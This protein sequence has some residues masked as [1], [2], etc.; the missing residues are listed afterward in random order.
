MFKSINVE[1]EN[2]ELILENSHGDKVII[3]A[4]KRNW[5]K[6]KLSEGCHDCIDSLV[7]TLPVASQY[8]QDGSVYPPNAKVKV[9]HNN[10]IKEYDISSPEYRDLYNSGK[11]MSYD[12]TTDTY[13]AT[14]LKEVTVT[15]EA[16]QWLKYKRDYEKTNP[17]S[18]YINNHLTPFAKS[19]GNTKT[20]Y[21]KR[22]DDEYEQKSL[23]YVSEQLIK[24]KPQGKL[25]RVEWLNQMSDKEEEL[26]KRNPKYQSSLWADT[27]RGLT[28]LVEQNPLQ[29]F[30]NILN[31]SDYTNREKQEMLKDYNNHPVMSKLGDATKILNPL[32][33]PSK[34]VQSSYKDDYSFSDAL[35]GKKN[36]AGIVED[37]VTDPLNLVGLGIWGKLSKANKFKNLD[38]AYNAIK[39]LDKVSLEKQLGNT[40]SNEDWQYLYR[41][42]EKGFDIEK[43][44]LKA[45][46]DRVSAGEGKWYDHNILNNP[47]LRSNIQSRDKYYGQWFDSDPKRLDYYLADKGEEVDILRTKVPKKILDQYRIDKIDPEIAKKWSLSHE[48]EYIVP[49]DLIQQAEKFDKK[50][51]Q[52]LIDEYELVN[53]AKPIVSSVDDVGKQAS[54]QWQLEELP[55]LHLK[56]T[57]GNNP[58][59]LHTQVAKDGS[60]NTENALKFIKNNEGEEKYN[61]IRQAFGK[62]LPNKMNYNEFRKVVQDQLIPLEKQFSEH[63]S[64]YGIGK[65]GYPS[66]KRSS[67]EAAIT[68]ANVE[69]EKQLQIIKEYEGYL[70]NPNKYKKAF[71][72][73][74]VLSKTNDELLPQIKSTLDDYKQRLVDTER[75]ISQSMEEMK[76]LPLENQTLILGNK[77][78]FGRGSSA[79]GNPDETLGHVHFLRDAETPDVL[80][81]TQIQSDAFQGT[82]R[83]MPKTQQEALEKVS[84]LK[85]EGTEMKSMFGDGKESS[86]SVLANY[87]KH[88]QLDEASAKNFTQKQ[89]LDKN[90]QE[91]YLQELVDY[92]GKRGDVNKVRVPTSETAAKVQGYT[93][94]YSNDLQ[95]EITKLKEERIKT[96]SKEGIYSDKFKNLDEQIKN[97]ELNNEKKYPPEHQTIIKKYSEQP[98]TIKKLFGQEPKIVT[99]KKGNTWY[100]FDIPKKFKEGKGEIKAFQVIPPAIGSA[101]YLQSQN[102]NKSEQ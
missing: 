8:A 27:K 3:P 26:I 20:N 51:W 65:L 84:K 25:S 78:K 30:Q 29:T 13:S 100:E 35:K 10:Q 39:T 59:G 50:D 45:I 94:T 49:K 7:E 89:L 83:I 36:N 53:T 18:N 12:K 40:I 82:H 62:T 88:L 74:S 69:K 81:V 58:K 16:P 2:L 93:K 57:M 52:K 54:K 75:Q 98:K 99:D 33:V 5:V 63:A 28:S 67:Y 38:E 77:S 23:D 61:L 32:T 9:N 24:N 101:L 48:T 1:A 79:H 17:K 91:R 56:S 37:I 42:Q 6:Q 73:D 97:F 95:K 102:Q 4:N 41:V 71:S 55:G 72:Y 19:L 15:A 44:T 90:H 66:P 96:A 87:E 60:I 92:A 34:M 21:P 11:L 31:S 68:H 80:T 70:K 43:P 14:P 47:E 85:K 64:N 46:E 76:L 86:N 22:L